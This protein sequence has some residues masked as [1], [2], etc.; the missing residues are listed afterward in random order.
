MDSNTYEGWP[1]VDASREYVTPQLLIDE[2]SD[3]RWRNR[4]SYDHQD[5]PF[6][7]RATE[8]YVGVLT[9]PGRVRGRGPG[10]RLGGRGRAARRR[11]SRVG[12]DGVGGGR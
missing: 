9:D 10:V 11:R 4:F 12:G 7:A 1:G 8:C 6:D 3:L 2:L 5:L